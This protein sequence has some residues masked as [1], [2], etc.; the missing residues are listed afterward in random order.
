MNEWFKYMCLTPLRYGVDKINSLTINSIAL[1]LESY[2]EKFFKN[3]ECQKIINKI[4]S[5]NNKNI[6]FFNKLH[7][8]EFSTFLNQ[9]SLKIEQGII[10]GATLEIP[11]QTLLTEIIH[12]NIDSI[13]IVAQTLK[14][15]DDTISNISM[16]NTFFETN[17]TDNNNLQSIYTEIKSI[18]L[19]Y[20]NKI[21]FNIKTLSLTLN[22]KLYIKILDFVY[23]NDIIKIGNISFYSNSDK[24]ML[25]NIDNISYNIDT[26]SLIIDTVDIKTSIIE[27]IPF[28]YFDFSSNN[29]FNITISCKNLKID[30]LLLNNLLLTIN[31]NKLVITNISS[32]YI[33]NVFILRPKTDN[34]ILLSLNLDNYDCILV[35]SI[36][37]YIINFNNLQDQITKIKNTVMILFNKFIQINTQT[38]ILKQ[39]N[40]HN[41]YIFKI[42]D[43]KI[44]IFYKDI[45]ANIK[46][47]KILFDKIIKLNNLICEYHDVMFDINYLEINNNNSCIISTI[48][49]VS[50]EFNA[51]SEKIS[52][53]YNDK[54]CHKSTLF[55]KKHIESIIYSNNK[56]INI[57]IHNAEINNIIEVTNFITQIYNSI[58]EEENSDIDLNAS[59]LDLSSSLNNITD[60]IKIILN[61]SKSNIITKYNNNKLL[62]L[63][64]K[65]TIYLDDYSANNIDVD[66]LI[67]NFLLAKIIAKYCSQNKIIANSIK[68]NLTPE[69]I[70]LLNILLSQFM[71]ENFLPSQ[72]IELTKES[73]NPNIVSEAKKNIEYIIIDQYEPIEK[74][75]KKIDTSVII[76][77]KSKLNIIEPQIIS[78]YK[79]TP[80]LFDLKIKIN[81]LDLNLHDTSICNKGKPFLHAVIKNIVFSKI[82]D[83]IPKKNI[84]PDIRFIQHPSL[85]RPN[86]KDIFQLAIESGAVLDVDCLDPEWKYFIKFSQYGMCKLHLTKHGNIINISIHLSPIILN[87]RE[88]TLIKLYKFIANISNSTNDTDNKILVQNFNI[89]SINVIFN[90]FPSLLKNMSTNSKIFT[91]KNHKIT[92]SSLKISYVD[93]ISKLFEII[94]K[95]WEKDA[96]FDNI[97]KFVPNIKII[98]PYTK[99]ITDLLR[100]TIKFLKNLRNKSL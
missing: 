93:S 11:L 5:H 6:I 29:K 80:D 47:N 12:I 21:C 76:L 34:N 78:N 89:N 77:T 22:N 30:E 9:N 56:E 18:L 100:S 84:V 96:D 44:S 26:E 71:S 97:I 62:L 85:Y 15:T 94:G 13:N 27:F 87:I 74:P 31:E 20:L 23:D 92:L 59:A 65:I 46:I 38:A 61:I 60:N 49:I 41:S 28:I 81:L 16:T 8:K 98:E 17:H 36:C 55:K 83:I 4:E 90:Y 53:L 79:E 32:I 24:I 82:V 54:F 70:N 3:E 66:F 45:I 42:N 37:L 86:H 33:D 14:L 48:K 51:V 57:N 75:K 19:K 7:L 95:K 1:I 35:Q 63:I 68:I 10:D 67:D 72:K 40:T 58:L 99:Y 64:K 25:V 69:I 43:I 73:K 39:K 52:I 2:R 91:I 88:E 50:K